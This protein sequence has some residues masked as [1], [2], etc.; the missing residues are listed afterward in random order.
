MNFSICLWLLSFASDFL[1]KAGLF[2][3]LSAFALGA[4]PVSLFMSFALGFSMFHFFSLLVARGFVALFD[5]ACAAAAAKSTTSSQICCHLSTPTCLHLRC[6]ALPLHS[7][8]RTPQW[9]RM[10]AI[11]S[12]VPNP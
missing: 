2:F 5:V 3:L 9:Q 7:R 10:I 11:L 4:A 8:K 12:N 1:L 6:R